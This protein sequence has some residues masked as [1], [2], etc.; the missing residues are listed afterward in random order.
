MERT[1]TIVSGSIPKYQQLL[2]ILRNQI[3]TGE[4]KLGERLPSE[5][6]LTQK[7][8]LSRGTVRKALAQLEAEKMIEVEHGIGSFVRALH[9]NSI[10]FRFVSPQPDSDTHPMVVD[11]V[12]QE[13]LGATMEVAER[14]HVPLGEKVIHIA[15]RKSLKDKAIS[16]TERYLLE[17]VMP[18]LA[19]EDLSKVAFLHDL[20]VTASE[21]PLLRAQFE[22]EAHL[23]TEEEAQLLKAEPGEP[24]IVVNRTTYTAP[25]RPAVWYHG[26]FRHEYLLD[27]RIW[28]PENATS[29][30]D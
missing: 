10:P 21:Y 6:E 16:F 18:S 24:A 20:L 8:G 30:E 1:A 12:V 26:I 28:Q 23:L 2:M 9:P 19:N 7:Y 25:N 11:T 5:E 22:V 15:R 3:I 17:E 27:I 4:F 13:V 29:Q 14:L